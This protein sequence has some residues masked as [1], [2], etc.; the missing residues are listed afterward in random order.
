MKRYNVSLGVLNNIGHTGESNVH[1]SPCRPEDYIG[2]NSELN[3]SVGIG[4]AGASNTQQ[5]TAISNNFESSYMRV[6]GGNV[7]QS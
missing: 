7:L 2:N 3:F 4:E 6:K 5:L 1:K